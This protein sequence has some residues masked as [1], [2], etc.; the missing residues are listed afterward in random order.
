ML[1]VRHALVTKS[2]SSFAKQ[3]G[4]LASTK[5]T[6]TTTPQIENLI[7]WRKNKRAIRAIRTYEEVRAIVCKTIT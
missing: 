6:A 3:L 7:G 4:D 1:H 2:V 5:G